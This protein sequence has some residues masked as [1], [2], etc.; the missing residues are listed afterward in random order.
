MTTPQHGPGSFFDEMRAQIEATPRPTSRRLHLLL[1][2]GASLTGAAVALAAV[3]LFDS[4]TGAAP[5]YAGHDRGSI[6]VTL[7]QLTHPHEIR[8]LNE[9]FR[10]LAIPE[11]VIPIT[12][13]CRSPDGSGP[14][15]MHPEP[16]MEGP[17]STAMTFRTHTGR[18]A[19]PGWHYVLAAKRLPGGKVLAFIGA[20]KKP[21]PTCL[22]YRDHGP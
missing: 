11:L 19:P 20:L 5:A 7:E 12:T 3:L 22:P 16:D 8:T 13:G 1:L 10:Q 2:G 9:R 21:I 15:V 6:R 14:I 17:A 18:P 4:T